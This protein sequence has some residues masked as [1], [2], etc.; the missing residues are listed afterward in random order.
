MADPR[1]LATVRYRL[2]VAVRTC[3]GGMCPCRW[4][5]SWDADTFRQT[6]G[7]PPS[8]MCGRRN[9]GAE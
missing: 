3:R 6:A 7:V 1:L 8:D 2:M 5:R 9:G 4:T